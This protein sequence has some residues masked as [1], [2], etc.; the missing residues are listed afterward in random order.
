MHLVPEFIASQMM[1]SFSYDGEST[2]PIIIKSQLLISET[3]SEIL[4]IKFLTSLDPNT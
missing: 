4:L 2:L 1:S 3:V